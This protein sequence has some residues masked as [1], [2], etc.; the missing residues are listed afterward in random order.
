M[1]ILNRLTGRGFRALDVGEVAEV[2]AS[3]N[4]DSDSDSGLDKALV[5]IR[6][7]KELLVKQQAQLQQQQR[8]ISSLMGMIDVLKKKKASPAEAKPAQKDADGT[9]A[10]LRKRFG[11]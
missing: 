9:M 7:Q 3:V 5:L 10:Q 11:L 6:Q 1:G 8:T 2:V 4:S